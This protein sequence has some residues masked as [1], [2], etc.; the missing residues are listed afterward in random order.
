[1]GTSSLLLVGL[2]D[3]EF[4][5]ITSLENYQKYAAPENM[6]AKNR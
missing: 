2:Y 5:P 4:Q 3:M 6:C 1:M